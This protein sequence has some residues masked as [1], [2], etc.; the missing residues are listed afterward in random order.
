[1]RLLDKASAGDIFNGND[2]NQI[3][4]TPIPHAVSFTRRAF[5]VPASVSM[6]ESALM[7]THCPWRDR[8]F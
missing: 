5:F 7:K 8:Q 2:R 4:K 1:M 3:A 6:A